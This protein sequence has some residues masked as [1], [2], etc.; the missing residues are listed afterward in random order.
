MVPDDRLEFLKVRSNGNWIVIS[1]SLIYDKNEI[2]KAKISV[3][4]REK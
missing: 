2:I 4:V 3:G 1:I